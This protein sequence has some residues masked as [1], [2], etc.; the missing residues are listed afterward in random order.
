[1]HPL[2]KDFVLPVKI[3]EVGSGVGVQIKST[4][5]LYCLVLL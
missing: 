2:I 1:M 3:G 5:A 4:T